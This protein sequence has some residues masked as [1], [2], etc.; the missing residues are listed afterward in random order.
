MVLTL[1]AMLVAAPGALAQQSTIFAPGSGPRQTYLGGANQTLA[2]AVRPKVDGGSITHVRYWQAPGDTGTHAGFVWSAT[3]TQL[4]T[5]SFAIDPTPGWKQAQLATPIPVTSGSTYVVGVHFTDDEY[6]ATNFALTTAFS[7]DGSIEAVASGDVAP[8]LTG[9]GLYA[10]GAAGTFPTASFNSSAYFVD[11]VLDH[12]DATTPTIP[13]VTG[14]GPVLVATDVEDHHAAY[15]HDILLAEG[16]PQHARTDARTIGAGTSLAPYETIVL[17]AP[18]DTTQVAAL[19]A[20]VTGGGTLVAIHPDPDLDA[21]LGVSRAGTQLDEGYLDIDSTTQPG[22]GLYTNT[23]QYHGSALELTPLTGTTTVANLFSDLTTPTAFAAVTRRQVGRGVAVAIAYDLPASIIAM[24]QGNIAWENQ[25]RDGASGPVRSSDMFAGS[26]AIDPQDDWVDFARIDVPQADEQQRLLAK[27]LASAPG[28]TPMPRLWYLPRQLRAAL[29]MTGDGHAATEVSDR[30]N[31]MDDMSPSGCVVA[32]WECRRGTW[33]LWT[34][35]NEHAGG[36]ISDATADG[37]VDRGY[38]FGLHHNTNCSDLAPAAFANDPLWGLQPQLGTFAGMYPSLPAQETM[39]T[40]C[41]VWT[42]WLD[43]QKIARAEGI[44]LDLNSYYW[45][46]TWVQNRPGLMTGSGFPMKLADRDGSTIDMWSANTQIT[47]ESGQT[48]NLHARTLLDNA[49][50]PTKQYFGA[51]VANMHVDGGNEPLAQ[52]VLNVA[53]G[54]GVPVISAEQLLEWSDT[55]AATKLT[56][57]TWDGTALGFDVTTSARNLDVLVPAVIGGKRIASVKRCDGTLVEPNTATIKGVEQAFIGVT[58]GRYAVSYGTTIYDHQYACT[59]VPA[60]PPGG[61]GGDTGGGSTS[62]TTTSTTITTT[63]GGGGAGTTLETIPAR[64]IATTLANRRLPKL[65]TAACGTVLGQ[66]CILETSAPG[67]RSTVTPT[68]NVARPPAQLATVLFDKRLEEDGRWRQVAKI[69]APIAV[70]GVTFT[71]KPAR[72][73]AGI[74][75]MR[76]AFPAIGDVPAGISVPSFV[77]VVPPRFRAVTTARYLPGLRTARCGSKLT[78]PCPLRAKDAG[79]RVS[80]QAFPNVARP[81]SQQARF[82]VE[83]RTLDGRWA[84]VTGGSASV[85][86]SVST[87]AWR[88]S[89]DIA[90]ALYRIRATFPKVARVPAGSSRPFYVLLGE[91]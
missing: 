41:V 18:V 37:W 72:M 51:F 88:P 50:D 12:P 45:P 34:N 67:L 57:T 40:H 14:A 82:V 70:D 9:N 48:L 59:G 55:R 90:S 77:R 53:V 27:L 80:V 4:A 23:M 71:W 84:T 25:Q 79:V 76:V 86:A 52:T 44:R 26:S 83:R 13:G 17:D 62:T 54:R 29:V 74:Y 64:T 61:G 28:A 20:F 75:R 15:L 65:A 35:H 81:A 11:V 24:R 10:S 2:T 85:R 30:V 66:P 87:W 60:S 36:A 6:G 69:T 89:A 56:D 22:A 42:T 7:H 38:G 47:D 39:R 58:T 78:R 1:L 31:R 16:I 49:L 33:Y 63:T 43:D 3:G 5:V 8:P 21:L 32:D 68:P 73:G 46:V 91:R 19:T